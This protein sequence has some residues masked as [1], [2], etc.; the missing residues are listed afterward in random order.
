MN[1]IAYVPVRK[2]ETRDWFDWGCASYARDVAECNVRKQ[3]EKYAS[4]MKNWPVLRIAKVEVKEV[5]E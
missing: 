4:V 5:I 3:D 2:G 1:T